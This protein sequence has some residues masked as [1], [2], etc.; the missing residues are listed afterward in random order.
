MNHGVIQY[1]F[2]QASYSIKENGVL[3]IEHRIQQPNGSQ[4]YYTTLS[5]QRYNKNEEYAA[6]FHKQKGKP[7]QTI[8]KFCIHRIYSQDSSFEPHVTAIIITEVKTL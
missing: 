2:V 7:S 5:Y 6:P 3:G 4:P 1:R 8:S